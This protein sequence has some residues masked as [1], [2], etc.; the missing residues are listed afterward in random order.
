MLRPVLPLRPLLKTS[1]G[2]LL[3]GASARFWPDSALLG[4]FGRMFDSLAPH[5]LALAALLAL[6]ALGFGPT[7]GAR[8]AAGGLL[9][10]AGLA[11]ALLLMPLPPPAEQ[12]TE[13]QRASIEVLWFNLYQDNPLPPADLAAALEA[14]GADLVLLAEAAPIRPMLPRL[15]QS[16]PYHSGCEGSRCQVL[17][18]SRLPFADGRVTR[19]PVTRAGRM[20]GFAL[21][22]PGSP[23]LSGSPDR[24]DVLPLRVIALQLPKP[25]FYGYIGDD[26]WH[27]ARLIDTSP[28][29]LLVA[30]D[31]N[32]ADWS[33]PM[34]ALARDTGLAGSGRPIATWPV[35]L[36]RF[37]VPI[38][39]LLT[40]GGARIEAA[41]P[42]GADFGS[43]H[44]G[45]R[46]RISWPL[47]GQGAGQPRRIGP[48]QSLF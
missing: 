4:T 34:R 39:H 20:V 16:F 48:E 21:A 2:L 31:F 38:D 27:L 36:G 43:N 25:W 30:G 8:I 42:W 28:G 18:L 37:G 12:S 44:L 40:R 23:D 1:F 24:P 45:L 26:R 13:G 41:R 32:A 3:I 15:A 22:P 5:L 19:P 6:P 17:V 46:A 29:P 9:G 7:R 35:A 10:L 14:S 47:G 33:R 11:C